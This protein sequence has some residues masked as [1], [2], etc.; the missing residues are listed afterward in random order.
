MLR[1]L[2]SSPRREDARRKGVAIGTTVHLY[3]PRWSAAEGAGEEI[4]PD[5][6]TRAA[7]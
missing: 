6:S 1:R 5:A 7:E 2:R 3:F 4:D